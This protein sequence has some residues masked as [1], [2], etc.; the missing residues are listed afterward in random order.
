MIR[1]NHEDEEIADSF[2]FGPETRDK[3]DSNTFD[4]FAYIF[5]ILPLVYTVTSSTRKIA[6]L[7]GGL[8]RSH[9]QYNL[10]WLKT[11]DRKQ[12]YD[13]DDY[14]AKIIEDIL[15]SDPDD[16]MGVGSSPRGAGLLFGPDETAE[17]CSNNGLQYLVRAH[18]CVMDGSQMMHDG[19]CITIFSAPNY[20]DVQG[21]LAAYMT[22]EG[23]D[24]IPGISTFGWVDHPPAR[25]YY[26]D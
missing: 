9:R 25:D 23:P 18:Q 24:M 4:Y 22:V 11:L 3:Y 1:G 14:R 10:E 26:D 2:G 16:K 20:C 19:K 13:E 7:H 5:R 15:W 6:V 12:M 21:N 17:F 8:Y